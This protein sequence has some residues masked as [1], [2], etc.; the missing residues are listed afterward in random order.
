MQPPH[1]GKTGFDYRL[2]LVVEMSNAAY[3]QEYGVE[4]S[5]SLAQ[6]FQVAREYPQV[7]VI[8]VTDG[9]FDLAD[10]GLPNLRTL[11]S[12]DPSYFGMKRYG[13]RHAR[14]D[15][16]AFADTD[17]TYGSG[18]I[19]RVL[20]AF[21]DP[22]VQI[23]AG[24][25]RYRGAGSLAK[26]ASVW[27]WAFLPDQSP[28]T[29]HLAAN[30]FAARRDLLERYE[31]GHGF[32]RAGGCIAFSTLATMGGA[33]I[34][35]LPGMTSLHENYYEKWGSGMYKMVMKYSFTTDLV[36]RA[37][38]RREDLPLKV[39]VFVRLMPIF[40]WSRSVLLAPRNYRRMRAELAVRGRQ[41]LSVPLWLAGFALVEWLVAVRGVL[42]PSWM[43]RRGEEKGYTVSPAIDQDPGHPL[44]RWIP[45][46]VRNLGQMGPP[47]Q[48]DPLG[49]K[50]LA[51]SDSGRWAGHR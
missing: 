46:I 48:E 26:A 44:H 30:N 4:G 49:S 3:W 18:W 50:R 2:S 38:A 11:R 27:D 33:T 31:F 20:D 17:C 42:Q 32:R 51:A 47:V 10:Q 29:R 39:R 37:I 34:R 40:I 16:I 5:A 23:V 22:D 24:K 6:F 13:L 12:D 43:R 14:G 25:T 19:Q 15:V 36:R 41:R 35:Y 9:P 7:E 1:P 28:T 45:Q 21:G 8:L